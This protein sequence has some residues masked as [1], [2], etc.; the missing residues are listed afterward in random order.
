[1]Y[2]KMAGEKL[3]ICGIGLERI[4]D[5][6]GHGLVG[7]IKGPRFEQKGTSTVYLEMYYKHGEW[8]LK[9][10][11]SSLL[12]DAMERVER[13]MGS[14]EWDELDE[15]EKMEAALE[16]SSQDVEDQEGCCGD[17]SGKDLCDGLD[18]DSRN[19]ECRCI[20]CPPEQTRNTMCMH[21]AL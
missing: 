9:E 18:C 13:D 5:Q 14:D 8:Q 15:D 21:C 16:R 6:I 1:M 11:Y 3:L 17:L 20:T 10:G 4:E 19:R 2:A 12:D 7:I